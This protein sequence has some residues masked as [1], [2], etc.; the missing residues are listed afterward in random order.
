MYNTFN[1]VREFIFTSYPLKYK[2]IGT[3]CITGNMK[4][5]LIFMTYVTSTHSVHAG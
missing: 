4:I 5:P 2:L 3:I 1:I